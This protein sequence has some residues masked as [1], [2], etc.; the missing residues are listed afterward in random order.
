MNTAFD[1][2][3]KH[4]TFVRSTE[5]GF[6]AVCGAGDFTSETVTR[7]D[8]AALCAAHAAGHEHGRDDAAAPRPL[9]LINGTRIMSDGTTQEA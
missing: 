1:A 9:A 7:E 4:N 8:A 6:Q 5:D 3:R 2:P